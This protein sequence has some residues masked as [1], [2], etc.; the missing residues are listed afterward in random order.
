[1]TTGT[2]ALDKILHLPMEG[3]LI[4]WTG[5][6]GHGKS[7][8]LTQVMAHTAT[9][10]GR[11]WAVFSPEMTPWE[12][13]VADVAQWRAGKPFYPPLV[14]GVESMSDADIKAAGEWA[15]NHFSL[16]VADDED[17]TLDWLIERA[18]AAVLRGG[19]T[20]FVIDPW[21]E[22]DHHW[23][24]LREDIYLGRAI[25]RLKAF[26]NRH[27]CNVHI[28]A[29]PT[30]LKPAKPG[31]AVPVPTAYDIAGGAMWANKPDIVVVVHRPE[32]VTQ[33]HVIKTRFRRFGRRGDMV[34][35]ILD[36]LT[37]RFYPNNHADA[38]IPTEQPAEPGWISDAPP[39]QEHL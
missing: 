27:G 24:G 19:A 2:Y 34:E 29:H 20:D 22:V 25:R 18:V 9:R 11:R 8:L 12:S 15:K 16:F 6:P 17:P 23:D 21:N 31:D 37:G 26:A 13:L 10:Y 28:V 3:R 1:M 32:T 14:P 38:H 36:P 4:V 7:T 5:I 39:P 30:K 33:V 35:I